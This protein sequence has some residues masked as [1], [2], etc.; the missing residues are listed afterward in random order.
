MTGSAN[1]YFALIAAPCNA[2]PLRPAGG[3]SGVVG[4]A[5]RALPKLAHGGVDAE[6]IGRDG[7]LRAHVLLNAI[8]HG[9]LALAPGNHQGGLRRDIQAQAHAAL[10]Q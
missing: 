3:L 1:W 9:P 8:Q 5:S 7:L 10:R 4:I 2:A 6:A